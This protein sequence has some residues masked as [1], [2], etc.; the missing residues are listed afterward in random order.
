MENLKILLAV[1]EVSEDDL[2][3]YSDRRMPETCSWI[4]SNPIYHAWMESLLNSQTLWINGSAGSGKSMLTSFLID[5]YRHQGLS[6]YYYFFRSGDRI[7]RCINTFLRTLAFQLAQNNLIYKQYLEELF[8]IGVRFEK[9]DAKSTWQRLFASASTR[10]ATMIPIFI[11]IDGL[12]ESDSPQTILNLLSS[13]STNIPLRLVVV[14]RPTSAIAANFDK[15]PRTMPVTRLSAESTKHDIPLF[16]EQEL[17]SLHGDEPFRRQVIEQIINAASGNFLWVH[18]ATQEVLDCQTQEEIEQVLQEIPTGMLPL[19]E[20]MEDAMVRNLR[21]ADQRLSKALLTWVTCSQR[22]LLLEELSKAVEPDFPHIIDLNYT[23]G[24]IC[25]HLLVIDRKSRVTLVHQTAR[26]YLTKLSTGPFA[27]KSSKAHEDLFLRC[28]S[29]LCDQKLRSRLGHGNLPPLSSYAAWS[30]S[31]H[32]QSHA[33]GS[34]RILTALS[35]FLQSPSALTWI[36]IL[37]MQDQLR[38]LVHSSRSLSA[39]ADRRRV[40]DAS[41]APNLRPIQTLE[42]LDLWAVDLVKIVGRFGQKLLDMPDTI[43]K[44]IPQ[45][46]PQESIIHRQFGRR[47]A[48]T[49]SFSGGSNTAWDDSLAKL[50]VGANAQALTIK[51]AGNCFAVLTT[52]NKIIIWDS[53]TCIKQQELSQQENIL[54]M[55]ISTSGK[56]IAAFAQG[57]VRIYETSSGKQLQLITHTNGS[58]SLAMAFSHDGSEIL[59]GSDDGTIRTRSLDDPDARW[60]EVELRMSEHEATFAGATT[61]NPCSIAFSPDGSQVAVAFRGAPLSVW[62]LGDQRLVSRCRRSQ[63]DRRFASAR[64]WTAANNVLWHPQS[65]EVIGIYQ[66]A[67]VFRWDPLEHSSHDLPLNNATAIALSPDGE[68]LATSDANGAV[69][70]SRFPDFGPIWLLRC[71]YPV[72]DLAFSP[73]NKRLYDIRGSF[74]NIWEPNSLVRLFDLEAPGSE[75][76]SESGITMMSATMSEAEADISEP[77]FALAAAPDGDYICV[78]N[79]EGA[80]R[81]LTRSGE[82][83]VDM[84]QSSNFMPV[85]QITWSMDGC[86]IALCDIGG[87]VIVKRIERVGSSTAV[88]EMSVKL[89]FEATSNPDDGPLEQLLL[90]QQASLL[91]LSSAASAQVWSIESGSCISR[92]E[93]KDANATNKWIQH[94]CQP[95]QLLRIGA[96]KAYQCGWQSLVERSVLSFNLPDPHEQPSAPRTDRIRKPS[97]PR[98]MSSEDT[99]AVVDKAILT[100]DGAHIMVEVTRFLEGRRSERQLMIFSKTEFDGNRSFVS[101]RPLPLPLLGKLQLPLDVLPKNTFV[102]LDNDNWLCSWHLGSTDGTTGIERHFFL[103]RGWLNAECLELCTMVASGDLIVPKDGEIAMITSDLAFQW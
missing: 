61:S 69:R 4:L 67:T 70:I 41:V 38:T 85:E 40:L 73:D 53:I 62:G 71:D 46:C 66:D 92:W 48:F 11:F 95:D 94:P 86:H 32:L 17:Q 9:S 59:V 24:H 3:F 33:A 88:G 93:S 30:W 22:P 84:W 27:I 54:A 43:F 19:Y 76:R 8:E 64:P 97:L 89:V 99:N 50:F 45:F 100:H 65:G 51:C 56:R 20:Q 90:N 102:F 44:F 78:G 35:A 39:F 13:A 29:C 18:L 37:A 52:A 81:L 63:A 2:S 14:S 36:Q 57:S 68:L 15:F 72:A 10:L 6:C 75:A 79:T 49:V 87:T 60:H 21:P 82:V 7:Q 74:C 31:F 55:C 103:P 96:E 34:E 42:V 83:A 25:G 26:E 80:V 5:H 101:P 1:S 12:D 28:M 91:L 58:R 16:V 98:S 77:I 23:I 47:S